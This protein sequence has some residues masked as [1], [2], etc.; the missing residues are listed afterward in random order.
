MIMMEERSVWELVF[1]GV[2]SP[3]VYEVRET[4]HGLDL[5]IRGNIDNIGIEE[6]LNN[7]RDDLV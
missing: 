5:R 2:R 3:Y 1:F 4:A 6:S 7:A